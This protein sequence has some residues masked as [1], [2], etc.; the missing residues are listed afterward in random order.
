MFLFIF[1]QLQSYTPP[2]IYSLRDSVAIW[3]DILHLNPLFSASATQRPSSPRSLGI[4]TLRRPWHAYTSPWLQYS[5]KQNYFSP[6]DPHH[7]ISKQPRWHHPCCA[8]VRWGLL[9][10]MSASSP[11]PPRFLLLFLRLLVAS[12]TA[13]ICAGVICKLFNG[14][15]HFQAHAPY[16]D[17]FTS[18]LAASHF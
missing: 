18:P 5:T 12:S 10:F 3:W 2:T 15:L 9:D 7:D 4:A 1:F 17:A 11:P 6:T 13:T 8:S 16:F 14:S